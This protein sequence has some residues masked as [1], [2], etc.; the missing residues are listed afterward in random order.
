MQ[1]RH[2]LPALLAVTLS[3]CATLQ[4]PI[5]PEVIASRVRVVEARLPEIRLAVELT[6]R[7]RNLLPLPIDALDAT[8]SLAGA[9]VGRAAL[10]QPVTLPAYGEASV[11]LDVRADPSTALPRIAAALGAAAPLEYELA[12]TLRLADGTSWPFR[13]RGAVLRD[14]RP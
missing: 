7:S 6:L 14:R 1:R 11:A 3:G 12:G 8:L 4:R 13:R 5:A 9:D 2:F 10:A